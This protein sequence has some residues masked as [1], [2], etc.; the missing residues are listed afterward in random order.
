MN[1]T[2]DINRLGLLLKRYFIENKQREL[3]FWGITIVVFMLMRQKVSA[4]M[5]LY[6]SGF[7]FAARAFKVFNYTPGGMHYLL[8]PATHTEKLIINILLSTFYF[9]VMILVTYVIG[10]TIGTYLGNL[11]FGTYNSVNYEL[12]NGSI[13]IPWKDLTVHSTGLIDIFFL[14]ALI[15]SIF[16]LGSVYFNR[17]AIGKTFLALNGIGFIIGIMEMFIIKFSF[18]SYHFDGNTVYLTIFSN[19]N[20][21]SGYLTAAKIFKILLIPFLW[22]ISYYRLTEKQV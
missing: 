14:F 17:N 8:I 7:I 2:L 18:G 11:I 6:I 1:T 20:F 22:V 13:S 21:F 4:E 9:F 5:F 10:T 15:Q 16:M 3:T 19:E 12:L